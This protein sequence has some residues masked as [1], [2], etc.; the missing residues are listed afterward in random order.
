VHS[1]V[2]R[3]LRLPVFDVYRCSNLKS[4]KSDTRATRILRI[5]YPVRVVYVVHAAGTRNFLI[6]YSLSQLWNLHKYIWASVHAFFL[7]ILPWT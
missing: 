7:E 2:S 5:S 3:D 4:G 1:T 6:M